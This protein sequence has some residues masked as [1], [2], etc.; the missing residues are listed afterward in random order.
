MTPSADRL[1]E[2]LPAVYRLRDADQRPRPAG[3][4]AGHRRAGRRRRGRSRAALRQLVHRDVRGLGRPVHR[5]ADR[6]RPGSRGRRARRR[7]RRRP[8]PQQGA[9]SRAARSPTRSPAGAARARS[10][11]LP[12][13][14]ARTRAGWPARAVEFYVAGRP[15]AVARAPRRSRAAGRRP[16]R[17][18]RPG[19]PRRRVRDARAHGRHAAPD[20]ARRRPAATTSRRR[21]CSS[22]TSRSYGVTHAPALQPGGRRAAVLHVQRARQRRPAVHGRAGPD[23]RAPDRGRAA[24]CPVADPPADCSSAAWTDLYGAGKSIQIWR[25]PPAKR[26]RRRPRRPRSARRSCRSRDRRRRPDRL[27]VPHARAGRSRSTRCSDGSRSRRIRGAAARRHPGQLPLR[28]RRR[29]RRRRVP[30]RGLRLHRRHRDLPR[31]RRRPLPAHRPGAGA[32]GG[33]RAAPRR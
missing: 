10:A 24:R 6:L 23:G 26:R 11:A 15:R 7:R 18:R 28:V 19:A 8:A 31:R 14:G 21:R 4:A 16:A 29:H 3:A 27:A 25:A 30:A 32:L 20:G 5:R 13:P 9:R 12:K 2:L 1:F 17:R 33:R 22:G